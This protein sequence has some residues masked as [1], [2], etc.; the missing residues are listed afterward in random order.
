[1]T[2]E[3]LFRG[4]VI[5]TMDPALEEASRMSGATRSQT[6]RRITLVLMLPALTS[7]FILS[8]ISYFSWRLLHLYMP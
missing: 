3:V 6:F 1:M 8:F 5:R 7:A 4:G 2:T